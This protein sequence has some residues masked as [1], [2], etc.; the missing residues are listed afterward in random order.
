VTDTAVVD[1]R[2]YRL[3][4]GGRDEFDR[5]FREEVLPMLQSRGI[6]VTGYG[7]SLIDDRH[8]YL[9]RAFSSEAERDRE[10]RSFYE[11]EEWR[12]RYADTVSALVESFHHLVVPA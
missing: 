5:I 8:Y 4:P 12:S 10:L 11:S 9:A 6:E 1:L 2:T 7:P 3:V